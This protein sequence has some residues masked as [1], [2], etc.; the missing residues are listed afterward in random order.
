LNGFLPEALETVVIG[1][2]LLDEVPVGP[3][4]SALLYLAL[5][6]RKKDRNVSRGDRDADNG[7]PSSPDS[8]LRH[9]EPAESRLAGQDEKQSG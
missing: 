9:P 4:L 1:F 2:S 8:L 5:V 6:N 7:P 3:D